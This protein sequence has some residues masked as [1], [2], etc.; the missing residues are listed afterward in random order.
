MPIFS[1][2]EIARAYVEDRWGLDKEALDAD[3]LR[4][5]ARAAGASKTALCNLDRGLLCL[6]A[7]ELMKLRSLLTEI[8]GPT[9]QERRR[10]AEAASNAYWD[11]QRAENTLFDEALDQDA[12]RPLGDGADTRKLINGLWRK[13]R[14]RFMPP[15]AGG[16]RPA[17]SPE[18]EGG[19]DER[20]VAITE[21]MRHPVTTLRGVGKITAERTAEA[22]E[23]VR[24][25]LGIADE[26]KPDA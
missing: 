26:E 25:N 5:L 2:A 23:Q 7:E 4:A 22:V 20:I 3:T 19:V 17:C 8:H 16:E 12:F 11:R 21:A 10:E 18:P 15:W 24:R 13:I 1:M 6:I 14:H 9:L